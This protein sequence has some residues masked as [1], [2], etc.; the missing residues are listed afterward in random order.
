VEETKVKTSRELLV[1]GLVLTA[2]CLSAGTPSFADTTVGFTVTNV[3]G[4]VY[5]Y[6][7]TVGYDGNNPTGFGQLEVY[8]STRMNSAT[9]DANTLNGA[10][11]VPKP[12]TPYDPAGPIVTYPW[13][14]LHYDAGHTAWTQARIDLETPDQEGTDPDLGEIAFF[15]NGQDTAAGTYQFSYRLDQNL[16]SFFYELH[17]AREA[18]EGVFQSGSVP[19]PAT[20]SL[21]ALGGLAMLRRRK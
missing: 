13:N 16:T 6:L 20:L 7:W 15:M 19:E 18:D 12:P 14:A 17:D 8:L 2:V 5:E 1:C 11:L 10:N 21:L 4:G 9:N 3:G